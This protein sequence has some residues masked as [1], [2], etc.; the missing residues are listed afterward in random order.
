MGEAVNYP[1]F[2][3]I[4]QRKSQES[5]KGI[6]LEKAAIKFEENQDKKGKDAESFM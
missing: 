4:R 1:I 3:K 5:T 2:V 6:A